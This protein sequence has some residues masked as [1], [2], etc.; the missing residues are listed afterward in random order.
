M[1]V[2]LLLWVRTEQNVVFPRLTCLHTYVIS[3]HTQYTQ[4]KRKNLYV[5][6][7]RCLRA[8]EISWQGAHALRSCWHFEAKRPWRSLGDKPKPK[9][10]ILMVLKFIEGLAIIEAG[11]RICHEIYSKKQRAAINRQ[12]IIRLLACSEEIPK[13]SWD[14]RFFYILLYIV[15]FS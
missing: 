2:S 8:D 5:Q 3:P 1:S 4:A 6:Y 9:E 15:I 14:W 11:I 12:R 10:R 13:V 7:C